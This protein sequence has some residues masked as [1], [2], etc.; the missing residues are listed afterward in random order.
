MPCVY[1]QSA[2]ARE[3]NN[4]ELINDYGP[5]LHPY[6]DYDAI[7]TFQNQFKCTTSNNA[8]END[9]YNIYVYIIKHVE[10]NKKRV[11]QNINCQKYSSNHMK[12]SG[13]QK[14]RLG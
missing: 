12:T 2:F 3:Q 8:T 9:V 14:C 4:V 5:Y 7:P 1:S 6:D 13:S 11:F 10:K